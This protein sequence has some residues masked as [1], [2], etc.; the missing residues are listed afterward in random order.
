MYF[1]HATRPDLPQNVL[2]S[3]YFSSGHTQIYNA[4][5]CKIH[6][7]QFNVTAHTDFLTSRSAESH[8]V[9]HYSCWSCMK[10]NPFQKIE[11]NLGVAHEQEIKWRQEAGKLALMG[12]WVRWIRNRVYST[13]GKRIIPKQGT[14]NELHVFKRYTHIIY[15]FIKQIQPP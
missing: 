5:A 13:Y 6:N 2:I 8:I 14:G 4:R 1:I 7:R 10:S 15:E 3:S 11:S 9:L 12:G